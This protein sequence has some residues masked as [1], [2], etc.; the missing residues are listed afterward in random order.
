[1]RDQLLVDIEGTQVVQS[2]SRIAR[3][4]T[5][6]S[7]LPKGNPTLHQPWLSIVARRGRPAEQRVS[8]DAGCGGGGCGDMRNA[9]YDRWKRS[10]ARRDVGRDGA[11]WDT[12]LI[13]HKSGPREAGLNVGGVQLLFLPPA[14]I[15]K[16]SEYAGAF[17]L[18]CAIYQSARTNKK[19]STSHRKPRR[20][21]F[22]F[23]LSSVNWRLTHPKPRLS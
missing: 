22:I 3:L 23:H 13:S 16:C 15:W 8:T 7:A 2:E 10:A 5:H 18:H 11:S 1:M 9:R 20:L 21:H 19:K 6:R 4:G 12:E 17:I 14:F